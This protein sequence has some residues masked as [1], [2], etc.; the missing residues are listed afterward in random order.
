MN[1]VAHG[2]WQDAD[3]RRPE[4]QAPVQVLELVEARPALQQH[5]HVLAR[6]RRPHQ[7]LRDRVA[8]AQ[9]V[10]GW[11]RIWST[12]GVGGSA[13]HE[14][15][16]HPVVVQR[17]IEGGVALVEHPEG[18]SL[19]VGRSARLDPGVTAAASSWGAA[20]PHR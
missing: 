16:H 2:E 11:M 3:A 1:L 6:L 13:V 15:L 18:V 19:K 20:G 7:R 12:L 10:Q 5:G 14:S 9:P 17:V 4:E 8:G